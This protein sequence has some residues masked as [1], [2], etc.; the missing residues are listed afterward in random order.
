VLS[1]VFAP[2]KVW[3]FAL[4][5]LTLWGDDPRWGRLQGD[6]LREAA[7]G[8]DLDD[9][10]NDLNQ[11]AYSAVRQALLDAGLPTLDYDGH[12]EHTAA[13]LEQARDLANEPLRVSLTHESPHRADA[14]IAIFSMEGEQLVIRDAPLPAEIVGRDLEEMVAGENPY[15][16]VYVSVRRRDRLVEQ[17]R[18]RPGDRLPDDDIV[19]LARRT[20]LTDAG[21]L[22]ELRLL[23]HPDDLASCPYPIFGD[24]SMAALGERGTAAAW[25]DRLGPGHAVVL[26]DLQPSHHLQLWLSMP[27]A[28][29]RYAVLDAE[30]SGR[31]TMV[32]VVQVIKG[33]GRSRL[34]VSPASDLFV[35]SI[36][37]WLADRGLAERADLDSSLIGENDRVLQITLGH[38][39]GEEFCF[40]FLAGRDRPA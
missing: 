31:T 29:L 1:R 35:R 11:R 22:V 2:E 10:W 21:R 9:V 17:W 34:F 25:A 36:R 18:L 26:F 24:L 4:S 38:M 15:E 14:D 37:A 32:F 40:D 23:H 28:R 5:A 8:R 27:E 19:V 16:H 6:S 33:D 20:V 3:A 39:L 30:R 7:F 12:T 13:V